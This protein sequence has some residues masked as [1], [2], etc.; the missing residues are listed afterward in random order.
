MAIDKGTKTLDIKT[1]ERT[2][3]ITIETPKGGD[4]TVTIH[5]ETVR[6][7]PDG[8]VISKEPGATVIRSLSRSAAQSFKIGEDVYDVAEIAGVI[9]AITDVWRQEDIDTTSSL[10]KL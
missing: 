6:T 8:S 3:R 9:A 5:R 2:W 7:A 1:E 10:P 4:P